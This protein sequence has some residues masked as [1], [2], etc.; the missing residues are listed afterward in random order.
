M[1]L[2]IHLF[3]RKIKCEE[4]PLTKKIKMETTEN[5]TDQKI[6]KQLE[7]E[8]VTLFKFRDKLKSDVKKLDIERLLIT[9]N[10]EPI[11]GDTEKLLDQAADMLTFGSIEPCPECGGSQFIFNKI[12]YLCN[13]NITEWT[14]CANLLT[15][16]TRIACKI[17]DELKN[18]YSFLDSVKKKPMARTVQYIPPSGSTISRNLNV[19]TANEN[20]DG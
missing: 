10:Q 1:F 17:P 20:I 6:M 19:K 18:L 4:L 2:N 5:D 9:N 7:N 3:D 14:K 11:I 16:P 13:G 12:G 8:N 15:K